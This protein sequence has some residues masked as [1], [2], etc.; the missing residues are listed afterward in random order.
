MAGVKVHVDHFRIVTAFE[1]S[2][3]GTA[4]SS[5]KGQEVED[6]KPSNKATLFRTPDN[7]DRQVHSLFVFLSRDES[8]RTS[9]TAS[10]TYTNGIMRLQKAG[11]FP[12]L[13]RPR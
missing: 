3:A 7:I 10:I 11:Y 12:Q 6:W 8:Q 9:R 4:Q 1:P 2:S 13:S 5:R